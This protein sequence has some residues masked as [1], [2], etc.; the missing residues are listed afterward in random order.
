MRSG[1]KRSTARLRTRLRSSDSTGGSPSTRASSESKIPTGYAV[2]DD[3]ADGAPTKS[4][5]GCAAGH[6]LQD[7]ETEGLTRLHGIEQSSR[8]AEERH[9]RGEVYLAGVDDV[10]A[11]DHGRYDVLIV[12]IRRRG[13][14]ETQPGPSGHVDRLQYALAFGETP[15][16]DEV[17]VGV[18]GERR[19]FPCPLRGESSPR[20]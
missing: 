13:E 15:K 7:D 16:E 8:P 17:V 10:L 6:G 3:L 12:V 1:P 20:R 2:V 18:A 9:L 4:G 11:V 5:N 19:T 14:H